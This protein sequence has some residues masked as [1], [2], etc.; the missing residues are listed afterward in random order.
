MLVLRRTPCTI[1]HR[2]LVPAGLKELTLRRRLPRQSDCSLLLQVSQE[3]GTSRQPVEVTTHLVVHLLPRPYQII[4]S[5][6]PRLLVPAEVESG[7][8]YIIL[9]FAGVAVNLVGVLFFMSDGGDGHEHHGGGF[10]HAHHHGHD[11]G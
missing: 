11:H 9:A 1:L 3:R 2:A 10:L 4:L 5:A 8:T 7:W 6:V